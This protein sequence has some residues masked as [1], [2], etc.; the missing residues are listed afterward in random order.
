M[1]AIVA[2]Q[3]LD[4]RGWF[5]GIMGAI[6]SGGAGAI[7]GATGTMVLDPAT[8]N[9]HRGVHKIFEAMAISFGFSAITS[10][11][12]YLK[13]QPIPAEVSITEVSTVTTTKTVAPPASPAEPQKPP[14]A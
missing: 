4:W 1:N 3:R 14:N 11:A 2:A 7:G 10:L 12:K 9:I 8:F 6:I 5:L 13:T